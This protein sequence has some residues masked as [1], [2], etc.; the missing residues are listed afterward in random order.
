M[1]SKGITCSR[2]SPIYYYYYGK[3][4]IN[5][6]FFAE[7]EYVF[8]DSYCQNEFD[9]EPPSYLTSGG[10]RTNRVVVRGNEVRQSR[11]ADGGTEIF[12]DIAE[13]IAEGTALID[14]AFA[15]E[16]ALPPLLAVHGP[17]ATIVHKILESTL[18]QAGAN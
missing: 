10:K 16:D 2:L 4:N 3:L 9:S 7:N 15:D 1:R 12:T 11:L 8:V 6:I 14:D 5:R 18:S 17:A 13:T